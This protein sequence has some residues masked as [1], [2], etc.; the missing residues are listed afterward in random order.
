MPA[1]IRWHKEF[2]H[3]LLLT[4]RAEVRLFR[5]DTLNS[6]ESEQE[7]QSQRNMLKQTLQRL[8]RQCFVLCPLSGMHCVGQFSASVLETPR[9]T[10]HVNSVDGCTMARW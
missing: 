8:L 1:S 2:A 3:R 4:E 9:D 5:V 10:E 6:L 7:C